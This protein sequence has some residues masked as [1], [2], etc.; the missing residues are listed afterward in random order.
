MAAVAAAVAPRRALQHQHARARRARRE[1]RAERSVAAAGDEHVDRL[2]Q[3]DHDRT[4]H[5]P[6]LCIQA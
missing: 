5:V 1:R 4:P 6:C 2:R 3:I